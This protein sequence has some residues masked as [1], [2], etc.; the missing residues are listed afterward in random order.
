VLKHSPPF[1]QGSSWKTRCLSQV[2]ECWRW[3]EADKF[4]LGFGDVKSGELEKFRG[5]L[6][7]K[8]ACY[9]VT[10]TGGNGEEWDRK[11]FCCVTFR[12]T[13]QIVIYSVVWCKF[14]KEDEWRQ[15]KWRALQCSIHKEVVKH[16]DSQCPVW[17][18][19]IASS[20]WA[21]N[22][23]TLKWLIRARRWLN[24][25]GQRK[26]GITVTNNKC[27]VTMKYW[28]WWEWLLWHG[29]IRDNVANQLFSCF[30]KPTQNCVNIHVLFT[31]LLMYHV[32]LSLPHTINYN[33]LLRHGPT[34]LTSISLKI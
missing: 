2:V 20:I 16:P 22:R 17:V 23:D 8:C 9:H 18:F 1:W 32:C 24:T 3:A 19:R 6:S 21:N 26:W 10:L 30:L 29:I 4:V 12:E 27:R 15:V 5:S 11:D 13:G 33:D 31:S 7:S 28:S 25:V 14:E 34:I